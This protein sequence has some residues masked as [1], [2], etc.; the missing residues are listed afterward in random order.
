MI[1][2]RIEDAKGRT[3]LEELK[4]TIK[5]P[6]STLNSGVFAIKMKLA[7]NGD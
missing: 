7:Q 5:N 6:Q 3:E 1:N 4:G 2:T